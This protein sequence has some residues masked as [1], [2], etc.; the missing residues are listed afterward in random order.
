MFNI[1]SKYLFWTIVAVAVVILSLY[2]SSTNGGIIRDA[3]LMVCA[4]VIAIAISSVANIAWKM[5]I[6]R[7]LLLISILM[8]TFIALVFITLYY[9]N[10]ND[11]PI[12]EPVK[13]DVIANFRGSKGA[14][15]RT[16]F[17]LGFSIMS[18][19]VLNMASKI[20]YER[21]QDNS[22]GNGFLRIYYQMLPS[23]G[24]EGFVGVFSD[25][26]LPP[27]RP[28]NLNKYNGIGF[29]MR[30]SQESGKMPEV[31]I[32]LY[33]DNIQNTK[34]AYPIAF[35]QP[36]TQWRN[37]DIPF[38]KFEAPPYAISPIKLDPGRVFRFGVMIVSDEQIHGHIDI[39]EI[40]L[41]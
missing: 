39:D 23:L 10:A 20:W 30:I 5:E 22:K 17:G 3:S 41:F 19:S 2:V 9:R 26:S 34:Q 35:V 21:L 6:K 24:H 37:Y 38:N 28:V 27:A 16:N 25:F 33:S 1:D 18:D 13:S 40:K 4:A 8:P 14:G 15:A 36:D 12:S 29:R 11:L 32:V 7:L 31:R